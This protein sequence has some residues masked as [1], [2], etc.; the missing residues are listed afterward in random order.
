MKITCKGD[1]M[2]LTEKPA[3]GC[4]ASVFP[5][6]ALPTPSVLLLERLSRKLPHVQNMILSYY[7]QGMQAY[8]SNENMCYLKWAR[9]AL[10]DLWHEVWISLLIK[11]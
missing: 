8:T 2:T 1:H 7:M 3:K 11:H 6:M 10:H 9:S 4:S 5:I